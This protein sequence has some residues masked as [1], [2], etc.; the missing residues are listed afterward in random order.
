MSNILVTGGAG[1]IGSHLVDEL[2]RLGH[3]VIIIDDLSTGK[4]EF[5]NKK[6]KFIEKDINN[7]NPSYWARRMDDYKIE[8]IFHLAATPR[9]QLSLDQ[10][11]D[12]FEANTLATANILEAGRL[13]WVKKIIYASSSSVYGKSENLPLDETMICNP[14]SPYAIQKYLSELLCKNYAENFNMDIIALRYFN[15]YGKRM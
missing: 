13:A 4:E 11:Y 2:I 10:P 7:E 12:T 14:Q 8:Y 15:V 3:R 5:I 1:F 9:I 6:V